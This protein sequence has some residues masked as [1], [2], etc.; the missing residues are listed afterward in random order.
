MNSNNEWGIMFEKQK[1]EQKWCELCI[2]GVEVHDE[3]DKWQSCEL[4]FD[5]ILECQHNMFSHFQCNMK[6]MY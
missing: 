1:E 5:Q 3:V 4:P 2:H 6:N